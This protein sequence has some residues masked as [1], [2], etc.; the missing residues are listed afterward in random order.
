MTEDV[1]QEET[2]L[3]QEAFD[4]LSQELEH[5]SGP[6]R[7]EIAEKIEAARDEGDL[8]ENGGYHAAREEQ[9]KQEARIRQLEVLLQSAKVGSSDSDGKT[10]SLGSVVTAKVAGNEMRFLLGS[11][12]I[13]GDSDID[14]FSEKSPL[15]SAVLGVAVGG[16]T[17]YE[18]PNGKEI[19]VEVKAIEPFSG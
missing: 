11:R 4:R 19:K 7:A 8:K 18:A 10:V 1:T 13:A 3:T 9:G 2:W 5:L 17:S 16:K 14:V 6:G 15:G 12:E